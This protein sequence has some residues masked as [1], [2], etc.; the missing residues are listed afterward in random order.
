MLQGEALPP[1]EA[2]NVQPARIAD[3]IAP[4]ASLSFM[5]REAALA[6]ATQ[7]ALLV[8]FVAAILAANTFL[9]DPSNVECSTAAIAAQLGVDRE[10]A[11]LEYASATS[12][13]SGEVSPGGNFTVNQEG[14]MNVVGVKGDFAGF[15]GLSVGFD[16]ASALEPGPGKLIDYTVRDAAVRLY[17]ESITRKS[18]SCSSFTNIAAAKI[19]TFL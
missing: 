10:L 8:R 11:T 5:A 18:G 14:A 2:P 7:A 9:H 1:G 16:F 3:Y 13:V 4:I 19:V 17:E 12:A 15:S 6:N